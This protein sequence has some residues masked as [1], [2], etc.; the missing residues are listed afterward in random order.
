MHPSISFLSSLLHS[1]KSQGLLSGVT[2]QDQVLVSSSAARMGWRG[3]KPCWMLLL[4]C[5]MILCIIL[6]SFV[7]LSP[8]PLVRVPSSDSPIQQRGEGHSANKVGHRKGD[9][10][11]S[12]ESLNCSGGGPKWDPL[13]RQGSGIPERGCQQADAVSVCFLET[14]PSHTSYC[15]TLTSFSCPSGSH[16]FTHTT[17]V[18]PPLFLRDLS[19]PIF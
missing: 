16:V 5:P 18:P 15:L 3:R 10:G 1:P 17:L 7:F 8:P 12:N 11:R 14:V 19:P 4:Q 2:F 6:R 13:E 9:C